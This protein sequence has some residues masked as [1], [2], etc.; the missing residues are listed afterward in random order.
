MFSV[1]FGFF[2]DLLYTIGMILQGHAPRKEARALN[3]TVQPAWLDEGLR[4]IFLS[5]AQAWSPHP[6][7]FGAGALPSTTATK[8]AVFI[9]PGLNDVMT[10]VDMNDKYRQPT[11]RR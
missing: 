6:E 3:K 10:A 1:E 2:L 4:K 8:A 5:H 7:T 11:T 9:D